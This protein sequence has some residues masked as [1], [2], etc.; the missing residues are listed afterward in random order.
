MKISKLTPEQIDRIEGLTPVKSIQ[1]LE[2]SMADIM[3]AMTN[4]GWELEDVQSYLIHKVLSIDC[5]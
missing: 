3:I 2:S 5:K 4:E 1:S